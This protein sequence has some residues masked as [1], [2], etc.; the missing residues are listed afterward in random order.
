MQKSYVSTKSESLLLTRCLRIKFILFLLF[1]KLRSLF[2]YEFVCSL[3][4][5]KIDK[6]FVE[7]FSCLLR[8]S[9][10]S[11][12]NDCIIIEEEQILRQIASLMQVK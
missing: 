6:L 1:R 9:A 11:L 4:E 3:Q 8:I 2:V 5:E 7:S 10:I 12:N